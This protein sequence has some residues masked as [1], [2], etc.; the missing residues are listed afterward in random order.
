MNYRKLDLETLRLA[1]ARIEGGYN[2]YICHALR[3]CRGT[4]ASEVSYMEECSRVRLANFVMHLL[5]NCH[6]Y[7]VWVRT[8]YPEILKNDMTDEIN[9]RK[10]R[11]A[12]MDWI[13]KK[14]QEFP[15]NLNDRSWQYPDLKMWK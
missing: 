10:G 15:Y 4:G 11:L 2:G 13:E 3:D 7:N 12:W 6:S 1:R 9:A 14:I 8:N 5:D